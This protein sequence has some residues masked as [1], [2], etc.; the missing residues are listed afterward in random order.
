MAQ[1]FRPF[2]PALVDMAWFLIGGGRG[3]V[4]NTAAK[5]F[6]SGDAFPLGRSTRIE[7]RGKDTQLPNADQHC[8]TVFRENFRAIA[9]GCFPR[10][11]RCNRLVFIISDA[12]ISLRSCFVCFPLPIGEINHLSHVYGSLAIF[13]SYRLSKAIDY[14]FFILSC[15]LLLCGSSLNILIIN[16]LGMG[17]L[18]IIPP[19]RLLASRLAFRSG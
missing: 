11:C 7:L 2:Y 8:Q 9:S 16:A 3:P 19:R 15:F 4:K 14:F 10:P 13:P 18:P 17:S 5:T 12:A 1:R 6:S